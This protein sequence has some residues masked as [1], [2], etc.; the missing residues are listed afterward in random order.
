VST[1]CDVHWSTLPSI[2]VVFKCGDLYPSRQREEMIP[3]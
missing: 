3:Y 2:P 1:R